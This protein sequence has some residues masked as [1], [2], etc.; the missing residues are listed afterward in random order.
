[1]LAQA[2]P[3]EPGGQV[4]RRRDAALAS[5]ATTSENTS[6]DEYADGTAFYRFSALLGLTGAVL[7][8]VAIVAY[9]VAGVFTRNVLG[10][11]LV[12]GV[13]GVLYA[14]PRLD[15]IGAWFRTRA[16]RQGGNVTLAS[17]A[18]I[19]LLVVGN[20]FANRHS[21]QWDL[22][23]TRRYTLSDQSL[24]VVNSLDRDVKITA[25]F[26]SRQEAAFTRGTRDLLRQY[27]RRSPRLTL[28][29]IDP[30]INPGAARQFDIKSYPVT[31]FQAGD[32]KEETA[33]V[34]EQDFTSALLKVTR[35]EK[36]KVYFL[37]GHQER[38]TDS[39]QPN[40]YNAA[41]E[42]LRRE[43]YLVEKLSLLSTQTVPEDAAVLVFAGPRAPLL[44]PELKSVEDYLE[45]G[46]HILL[47]V[48]PRQDS[49]LSAL[50]DRWYISLGN[51]I[52]VDPGR[53]YSGDP[54][55]PAPEPQA[56][57]RITTTLPTLLLPG[58]RSVAIKP[59]AGSDFAIA[60]LLRTTD[61]SWGEANIGGPYRPD[62]PED[63]LGPLT[64]AVAVN[65]TDPVQS[66]TPGAAPAPAPTAV[67][68]EKQPRGRMVVVGNA[69]FATNTYFNQVLGNRDFFINS[70]NWLAEDE[71]LISIRAEPQDSAP[72]VLTNQSQVLVFYASV[73]FIPLSVLL[74]GAAIWW[75]RR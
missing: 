41:A 53:N 56:G 44:E 30:D 69:E 62:P 14:I 27:A 43:N 35:T 68:G 58:S 48:E 36:K 65:K 31:I 28:E 45:R 18:F 29:F 2:P 4:S 66:I 5:G 19:G 15:Q 23:A 37:Q 11:L 7:F 42:G 47:L 74:L 75:Q 40:G 21:P 24:K 34:T 25:F 49:G 39:A 20:W 22:T 1:M 63:V 57:H 26:P 71:D 8:A 72:I 38:D 61:R 12:A 54:L 50:L 33:G 13:L 64:V 55:T 60:P 52:V 16:A 3:E 17:V 32:R 70:V 51:N 10:L 73:V 46:G 9:N 59:G 67:P 6:A